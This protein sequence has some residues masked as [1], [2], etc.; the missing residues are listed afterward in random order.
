MT[1][2]S[3]APPSDPW[4]AFQR[5]LARV[6]RSDA[7]VLIEGEP[8]SGKTRA[9]RDLHA[10]GPRAAGPF[11]AID[12]AA[13]APS[14]IEADLFG[15]EEGA[16]TGA[17]QAR[18]G[19]IR[20]AHGGTL[21]LEG[22]ERLSPALQGK[23]LRVLQER[24][25]E[26]LGAE[27]PVAVD[28]RLVAT[29]SLDLAGAV[30]AGGFREDLYWRLAVVR[31]CVPPLRVRSAGFEALVD[32]LVASLAR[33]AGLPPR[34]LSAAARQRLARHPWPGNVRELENAL[35]RV[36]VLAERDG[37]GQ[38]APVEADELEFLGESVAGAAVRLAREALAQ[39][40]G[41]EELDAR[42]LELALEEHRGN[43]SAAARALGLSRRAF[44]YRWNRRPA[45]AEG[46]SG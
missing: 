29:S 42:L 33:R 22:I 21:V 30:A 28:V 23:L 14:L 16:F 10:A 12:L 24:T 27:A 40:V 37:D 32:E 19:R 20:R 41:L 18:V 45:P 44:E 4:R 36:T 5:D 8:G 6:A 35:E 34:A 43:A 11:V 25:V 1:E 38:A 9:A 2:P 31:L 26:P 13:L 15:H 39:G 3:Q 17:S 7:T 46:A